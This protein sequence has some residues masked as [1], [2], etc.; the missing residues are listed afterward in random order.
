[1]LN[2]IYNYILS[3]FKFHNYEDKFLYGKDVYPNMDD[4]NLPDELR[5]IGEKYS[6]RKLTNK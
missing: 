1:M 4:N 5:G 3:L 2:Y 6:N